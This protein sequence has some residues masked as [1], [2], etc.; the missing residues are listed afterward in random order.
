M[1]RGIVARGNVGSELRGGRSRSMTR[2]RG[3]MR[4]QGT[5]LFMFQHKET[6]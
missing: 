1:G 2:D 5:G 6:I 4:V 3:A